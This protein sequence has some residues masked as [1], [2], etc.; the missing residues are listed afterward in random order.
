MTQL[1]NRSHTL[2][3][4]AARR[5]LVL[6]GAMGT[7]LQGYSLE[8]DDYRGGRFDGHPIPLKGNHDLLAL[9][10]PDVLEEV[11]YLY[12]KAGADIAE[13]NTFS[14]NAISQSDYGLEGFVREMN[15][16]AARV[17][18]RAAN[19]AEAE[20]PTRPRFVCGILGPTNRTASL[21]PK[22]EDPG[23]RNVGFGELE[24][25]YAEQVEGLLDGGVDLF[26]V[27]TIFDTLNAK[28]ALRAVDRVME[29][30]GEV[31]P[32]MISG[33]LTDASGRTLSGQTLE[34]FLNSVRHAR[35]FSVGLNCAL[36]PKQLR[37]YVEELST[38]S[39]FRTS[40][41][42]NAGLPNEFGGYDLTP[43]EMAGMMGEFAREGWVNVA[44]GCCGTNPDHIRAIAAAVEG[45]TPRPLP[46]RPIRCRLSGLEP[47]NIGPELLFVN[48]GER[49]NVTGSRR[50]RRL[51]EEDRYPEALEVARQQVQGGAQI[52]D[53]NMDE[54]LLDSEGA[55]VRVLNLLAAEP[56]IARIPVMVDSSRWEVLEAGLR[57][58]QGKG[59]VNSIS[60]KDGEA[61]FRERAAV[62]RSYG[63]AVVVMAFDEEGQADTMERKVEICRRAYRILTE[64]VGFPPEDIIFD[65][66]VFAIGTGIAEHEG[67]G[68]A[69]L[70]AVKAIKAGC[71]H[72]LT[73]GGISNLSFSFRGSPEVREALHTVFLYH[74]V[75]AGL[76]MGIV[77]AGALP[78]YDEIPAE[79]REA[80]EDLLFSRRPDATERFTELAEAHKGAEG[81][82]VEDL[83]WREAE[84]E[85]RLTH[86]LVHGIDEFVEEDVEE[87]RLRAN[88][89]IEVIE[90]PLMAGMN[91]V[92]DL[93]GDGKMF[94]PQV[95]KSARVMKRAVA[96]LIPHIEA[97]TVPGTVE[98]KG[99]ILLATVKGDVHDIGKNIVG[100]VLQCNGYDVV[101]LGVMVPADRIVS[102]ARENGVEVIGLSGL[103]TPSLDEMVH[104]AGELDREGFE[105]PLLI[106][107]ATTSR[108]HTAVKIEE[109]YRGPTVH[110]DDAS[111][112]VG[113]VRA[114]LTPRER[115][116]YVTRIREE[117]A[118]VRARFADRGDRLPLLPWDEARGNAFPVEWAGY[119]PPE[120]RKPGVHVV[121]GEPLERLVPYIDWTPFFQAW[122]LKGKHPEILSDPEVGE[123][124]SR[125]LLDAEKI[126]DEL[127]RGGEL[128]ARGVLGLFPANRVGE[129]IDVYADEGRR[130]V[131]ARLHALRQQFRKGGGESGRPNLSLVDFVAP[132]GEARDW[133]GA[134]AVTTGVGLDELVGAA[135]RA[136]DDYR[137]ILLQSLAD[138]LA[139]AFAEQLHA[140]VRREFW[141]Y[142]ADE[143][144]SNEDLIAERYQGIRPAP[145]YPA[146]PDHSEKRIL[147]SLLGV[148]ERVGISLTESCAM[149]PTAAVSGWYLSH[150]DAF[151]FGVGRIGR[152]QVEDYAERKGVSPEEAERWLRPNLAY[153]PAGVTA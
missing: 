53:V 70:E 7:M 114:L 12:Y 143:E 69:F 91:R 111:R 33:T 118:T 48:V 62:V 130:V 136:H 3:E 102:E 46:E 108:T 45:V 119:H 68:V 88:R 9:T 110:V 73:S 113:V 121:D 61:L 79:L 151:Y 124:A 63:A 105:I 80:C 35:P 97:E 75:H 76:D 59:V 40:C 101:D 87:A 42:P 109:R 31:L 22:V 39:E 133:I 55:M 15:R 44:G 145:G 20:D 37:P 95:V 132:R 17:A 144:L 93:F 153:D 100:V 122:E 99:K 49:T 41:H 86:A 54:G 141:G 148:E 64:E 78:V 92:G 27:E 43:Q 123:A 147:F 65:P 140:R 152:D 58:L 74:G 1:S 98:G 135:R 18:R 139:E 47:L 57:C 30:R 107:G 56:E 138:R 81:V 125:L 127:V 103:I 14:A 26:M 128:R 129:D 83:T 25:A 85:A 149:I 5:I 120:P 52:L 126:L 2:H 89:A 131:R 4:V 90:G 115:G 21:S 10:R 34:A 11:H 16:E 66:N 134:F 84:A 67:Y 150:P 82:R 51:I 96:Y 112:A 146:C 28:A 23:F 36:G 60:L 71:P 19:R 29:A 77:N 13:T 8:E 104:V 106:G 116:A 38:I 24:A 137:A 50:F 142:A 94:L 6:D 117:Y 32:V 72:A